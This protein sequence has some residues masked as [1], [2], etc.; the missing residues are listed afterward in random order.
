MFLKRCFLTTYWL[1]AGCKFHLSCP[2]Q[3][4]LREIRL[5]DYGSS[6]I[7]KSIRND[8]DPCLITLILLS[9]IMEKNQ[10]IGRIKMHVSVDYCIYKYPCDIT[11]ISVKD[12]TIIAKF[13]NCLLKERYGFSLI[14]LHMIFPFWINVNFMANLLARFRGDINKGMK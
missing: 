9:W 8:P 14:L 7:R 1:L 5:T 10:K 13:I 4:R 11:N 3:Q 6:R 12:K 2:G